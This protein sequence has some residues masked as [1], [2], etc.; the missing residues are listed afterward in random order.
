V[1]FLPPLPP[2]FEAALRDVRARGVQARVAAADRLGQP[3]PAERERA[4]AALCV[5]AND[6]D[7]RVRAASVRALTLL[8]EPKTLSALLERLQ[9]GDPL[10]RELSVL[11]LAELGGASAE[12]ALREALHSRHPEVRFQ[13]VACYAEGSEQIAALLEDEDAK[14]RAHTARSLARIGPRARGALVAALRD[15]HP[16]VRREAAIALARI[17]HDAG[18]DELVGALFDPELTV[19]ALDAIGELCLH[20]A[21][22]AITPFALGFLRPWPVRVAAARALLRLGD[23]RGQAAL[24]QVLAGFRAGGRSYAV[25]IAGELRVTALAPALARLARRPRG[26]D[27]ETL[28]DAL[29]AL[30][31]DPHAKRGLQTLAQGRGEVA[32]KARDALDRADPD[33][34][35]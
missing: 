6:A 23:P 8:A 1:W 24:G 17:G 10:V 27:P 12:N 9:D 33:F 31:P 28:A 19:E 2:T 29:T 5:L 21:A 14:V 7:A 34:P 3:E 18:K 15:A 16:N 32:R 11:A 4:V 20:E 25:Q 26:T 22:D 30:L 13:A 35:G